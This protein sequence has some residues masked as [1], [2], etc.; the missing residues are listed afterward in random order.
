MNLR[1]GF[2]DLELEDVARNGAV[3]TALESPAS[4]SDEEEEEQVHR[5]SRAEVGL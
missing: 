4:M 2:P 5:D 1:P 3:R